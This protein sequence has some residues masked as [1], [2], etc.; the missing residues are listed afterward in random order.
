MARRAGCDSRAPGQERLKPPLQVV[1][2]APAQ[3]NH[4][5][6]PV[7]NAAEQNASEPAR[8]R[9]T[10]KVVLILVYNLAIVDKLPVIGPSILGK[11]IARNDRFSHLIILFT[12]PAMMARYG[13]G[14]VRA[15]E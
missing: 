3:P 10:A 7:R 14:A 4:A 15:Q 6:A 1:P 11:A 12:H 8:P 9:T 2:P 13:C 5:A